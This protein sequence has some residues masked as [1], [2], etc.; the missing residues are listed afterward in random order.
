MSALLKQ[1]HKIIHFRDIQLF[2]IRK[3]KPVLVIKSQFPINTGF[4]HCGIP[5][6]FYFLQCGT[7]PSTSAKVDNQFDNLP[8]KVNPAIGVRPVQ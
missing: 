3:F 2:Q 1:A 4:R 8:C 6:H 7:F 5:A